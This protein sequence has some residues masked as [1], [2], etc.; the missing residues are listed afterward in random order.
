MYHNH[1]FYREIRAIE[2][3]TLMKETHIQQKHDDINKLLNTS[4]KNV[5]FISDKY[6][7]YFSGI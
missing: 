4:R 7:F 2:E 6:A 1:A 5:Y 3:N